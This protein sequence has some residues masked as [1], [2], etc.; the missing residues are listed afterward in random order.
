MLPCWPD[1]SHTSESE[2]KL[3]AHHAPAP[4]ARPED[5]QNLPAELKPQ[6]T[7]AL[8]GLQKSTTGKHAACGAHPA[9]RVAS[10]GTGP[11][12]QRRR[13]A[14]GPLG[15]VEADLARDAHMAALFEYLHSALARLRSHNGRGQAAAVRRAALGVRQAA[16][17]A[18]CL[19]LVAQAE[20][21]AGT[22]EAEGHVMREALDELELQMDAAEALWRAGRAGAADGRG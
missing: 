17:V 13:S 20:R 19:R 11:G 12:A 4:Q 15:S 16:A 9:R 18:G 21:V 8:R 1:S 6:A 2:H 14:G 5:A 3:P 22:A 10:C 7:D